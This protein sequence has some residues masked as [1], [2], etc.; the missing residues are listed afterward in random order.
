MLQVGRTGR[1]QARR[2]PAIRV[3]HAAMNVAALNEVRASESARRSRHRLV[4]I[5]TLRAVS[6]AFPGS[7]SVVPAILL[8]VAQEPGRLKSRAILMRLD[9]VAPTLRHIVT[10]LASTR[11]HENIAATHASN[12]TLIRCRSLAGHDFSSRY[13]PMRSE[14]LFRATEYPFCA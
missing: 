4:R 3:G 13:A 10:R 9:D 11:R 8:S 6:L 12:A 1:G 2:E 5:R 14:R 7:L